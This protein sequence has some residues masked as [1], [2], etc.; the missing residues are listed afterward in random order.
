MAN[1][2]ASQSSTYTASYS[3]EA[4]NAIDG[5]KD[6]RCYW[7]NPNSLT[8]TNLEANPWWKVQMDYQYFVAT[9][10]ISNRLD[11]C[12]ERLSNYI[13]R[14]GNNQDINLNPQCPGPYSGA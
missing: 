4:K 9:V 13:V 10:K 12:G 2:V 3:G 14:V 5:G 6:N 7:S 8:H 1:A 11:C